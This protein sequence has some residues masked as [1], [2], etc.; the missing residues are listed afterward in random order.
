MNTTE[1]LVFAEESYAIRAAIFE[2]YRTLGSGYLEEVYQNALE[3]ELTIRNIAYE[4]KKELNVFYK[5]RDCGLYKPDFVCLDK[6]IVEIKAV[7]TLN[8]KH[9][10]QLKNYLTATG[11]KLGLLVN[12]SAYPKVEIRRVVNER[13]GDNGKT[14]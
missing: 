14:I 11:Y 6:V 5:G 8:A 3:E 12:F 9:A 7:E 2:V 1:K 4:A 13:H 10:A